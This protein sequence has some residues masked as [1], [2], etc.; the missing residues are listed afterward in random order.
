[1]ACGAA[2]SMWLA[3]RFDKKATVLLGAGSFFGEVALLAGGVRNATVR[4]VRPSTLLVLDVMDFH[5]MAAQHSELARA[6]EAEAQHRTG[7]RPAAP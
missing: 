3:R 7:G 4:T 5:T 2:L 6:V 1:M